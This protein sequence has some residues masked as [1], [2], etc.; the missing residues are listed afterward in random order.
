MCGI[1]PLA[2]AGA[3]AGRPWVRQLLYHLG[4]LNT[5]AFVGALAGG[6]G[7][8]LVAHGPGATVA[9][10]LAIAAGVLM[11]VVGLEMLG[12][13]AQVTGRAAARVQ[14]GV[15]LLLG[16]VIRSRSPL[17][18]LAL[19]VF[20]AFLPCQLIYAFA[21]RAAATASVREGVLTMVCFGLGTVPAMLAL[22]LAR[23]LARPLVRLRLT[24]TS[25]IGVIAFGLVTLLRGLDVLGHG[26][27]FH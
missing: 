27:H 19:G 20:N 2:L 18:P 1:F 11:V 16:G 14:S 21:A 17:A 15:G 8:V 6:S 24:R 12:V 7:A 25:A 9:R 5:L 22:G 3:R 10:G 26:A 4:R 13:L 23:V